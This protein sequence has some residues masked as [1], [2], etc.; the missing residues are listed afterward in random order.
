MI[1]YHD[2]NHLTRSVLVQFVTAQAQPAPCWTGNKARQ[3]VQGLGQVRCEGQ[4]RA[5]DDEIQSA[6]WQGAVH[7]NVT[8][9]MEWL[10]CSNS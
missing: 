10:E 9:C 6:G 4:H 5:T 8:A 2:M 7:Q 1:D 3:L